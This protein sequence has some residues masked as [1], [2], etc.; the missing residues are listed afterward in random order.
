M[1]KAGRRSI[2]SGS[3]VLGKF[4][5]FALVFNTSDYGKGICFLG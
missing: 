2:L 1:E 3:S 4:R 5:T